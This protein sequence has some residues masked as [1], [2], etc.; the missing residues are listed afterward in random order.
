MIRIVLGVIVG[1]LVAAVIAQLA[2]IVWLLVTVGIPLGAQ[3]R[4]LRAQDYAILLTM[5]AAAAAGGSWLGTR[6]A[7][8]GR[9]P[10]ALGLLGLLPLSAIYAF[11]GPSD[12]P[13]GWGTALAAAAIVGAGVVAWRVSQSPD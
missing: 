5:G 9:L 13:Q 12:W 6:V 10:V 1:A 8:R 4:P 3:P 2:A 7:P 11:R